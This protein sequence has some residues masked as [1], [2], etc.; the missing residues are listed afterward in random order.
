MNPFVPDLSLWRFPASLIL[1]TAFL[2]ALWAFDRYYRSARLYRTLTGLRTAVWLVVLAAAVVAAEGIRGAELHR[3][4]PFAA[5][6][7][8]LATSLGLTLLRELRMRRRADFLLLHGGLFIVLWAGLF[9]A[10]DLTEARMLVRTGAEENLAY[11]AG[12]RTV[13]LPFA[14]RLD[15]FTVERYDDGTPRR[16][17]SEVRFGQRAAAIEVNAP[18]R[19]G[20]YTFYQ[21]S[22]DTQRNAYTVLLVVRDPWLPAAACGAALLAAGALLMLLHRT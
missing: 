18:V 16:F 7:L 12:G 5:L 19:H 2:L 11:T 22:Y 3:T 10:P 1:G 9:G 21:D 17:R 14:V 15:R 20:G 4:W 13:P 6:M 8:G